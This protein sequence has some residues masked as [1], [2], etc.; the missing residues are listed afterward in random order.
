MKRRA[1]ALLS[2]GDIRW[3]G[4]NNACSSVPVSAF[5]HLSFGPSYGHYYYY[6]YGYRHWLAFRGFE[7][8]ASCLF[9]FR[10]YGQA[11]T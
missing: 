3:G 9:Y 2:S 5:L 7:R 1:M 4:G 11:G 10:C 6:Y 8:G